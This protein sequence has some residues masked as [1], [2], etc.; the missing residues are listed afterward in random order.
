MVGERQKWTES[1]MGEK[2]LRRGARAARGRRCAGKQRPSFQISSK[3]ES[4]SDCPRPDPRPA[5]IS[6]R[7]SCLAHGRSPKFIG[8]VSASIC[9]DRALLKIA[10][11]PRY[12]MDHEREQGPGVALPFQELREP[13]APPQN[14]YTCVPRDAHTQCFQS[15]VFKSILKIN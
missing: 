5:T 9:V 12:P 11:S 1:R 10:A 3:G 7:F 8:Y 15:W 4:G 14:R 2:W 13:P 6:S